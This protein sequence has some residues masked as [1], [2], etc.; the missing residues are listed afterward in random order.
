MQRECGH[1][2]ALPVPVPVFRAWGGCVWLLRMVP[3][4]PSDEAVEHD[5]DQAAIFESLRLLLIAQILFG[6]MMVI[7]LVALAG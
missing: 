6:A 1:V 5:A 3:G 4:A 2:A 7:M